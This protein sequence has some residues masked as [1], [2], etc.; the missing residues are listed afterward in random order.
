LALVLRAL[1]ILCL[2]GDAAASAWAAA[3]HTG[4]T[5]ARATAAPPCHDH[6]AP[7]SDAHDEAARSGC[8]GEHECDCGCIHL[9]AAMVAPSTA[10]IAA[11][12]PELYAASTGA[13]RSTTTRPPHPPP[14]G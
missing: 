12:V 5:L 3:V 10:R 6:Q 14:I 4:A 13:L 1:L 7:A 8:C 11:S 9:T 2:L